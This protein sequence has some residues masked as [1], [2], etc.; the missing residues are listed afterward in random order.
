MVIV[1][2]A[3][4][5]EWGEFLRRSGAMTEGATER[6]MVAYLTWRGIPLPHSLTPIARYAQQQ[7]FPP[8]QPGTHSNAAV[9]RMMA[10]SAR[11][12]SSSSSSRRTA[13][14]TT[15]PPRSRATA[16][17]MATNP[18]AL[19]PSDV[20]APQGPTASASSG[21]SASAPHAPVTTPH[22]QHAAN[23]RSGTIEGRRATESPTQAC[24]Q[25]SSTAT[26]ATTPHGHRN[27]GAPGVTCLERSRAQPHE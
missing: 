7:H 12:D 5:H 2:G 17:T 21:P 20:G 19:A 16:A 26:P 8:P 22:Q 1:R 3:H 14:I 10:G 4:C 24:V 27:P 23:G 11:N 6:L 18:R 9:A 15:P 25:R 13:T